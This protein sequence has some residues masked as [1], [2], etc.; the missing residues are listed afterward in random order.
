MRPQTP[1][2]ITF[3]CLLTAVLV[4]LAGCS[5]DEGFDETKSAEITLRTDVWRMMEGSLAG[6]RQ[7]ASGLA[8]ATRAATFD[9][10]TA[11]RTEGAFTC[12]VFNNNTM[13]PYVNYTRVDWDGT[14]SKWTFS[15]GKHYWPASGSLDFFAYMPAGAPAYITSLS[16]AAQCPTFSCTGMP[17]T[18]AAQGSLQEFVYALQTGQNKAS[19]GSTGVTM[20]FL[21]PFTRI[22]LV[23]A[24]YDHTGITIESITLKGIKNNG[25]YAH[26]IGWTPKGDNV[27][28]TA[29]GLDGTWFLMV[30]QSWGGEIEVKAKWND[31]GDVLEH[32]LTTTAATD[33]EAGTSYTYSF[34]ISPTDLMVSTSKYTEQW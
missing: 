12:G 30:P 13:T 10:Q 31:W 4:L 21:H 14:S 33:W 18:D 32:T 25:D 20:T 7:A 29:T 23:W 27:S 22:K 16:Y 17:M 3:C 9:N 5:K 28:F 24:D 26:G 8:D 6:A 1:P 19:Q 15:D 34:R 2:Y 11:L